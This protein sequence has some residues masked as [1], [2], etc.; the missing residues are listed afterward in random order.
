MNKLFCILAF[1]SLTASAEDRVLGALQDKLLA[2]QANRLTTDD[3]VAFYGTLA[4]A[5]PET[6]QYQVLL[7]GA[8]VQKMRET[9][10]FGYV[11]R[12]EK[13]LRH[14]LE[15]DS[16]NYE[17]LRLETEI[18]L[19]RHN[20]ATVVDLSRRLIGTAPLDAWNWGTLG[21]AYIELG[22]YG[23]AADAYQKMVNLRPDLASY[24]RAAH[25]RYLNNDVKG[26]IASMQ[27]AINAGSNSP[28][29]VAWCWV[30]LGAYYAKTGQNQE[31][32]RAYTSA[33]RTFSNYHPAY[34]AL[35]KLQAAKG[36]SEKAIGNLLRAQSITPLPD[37]A[38]AL[39]DLYLATGK[40][41]EASQ[42]K[43]LIEVID[44]LGRANGEKANRNLAL[45]Y[46]DHDWNLPRSLELAT[47]ELAYRQDVYTYDALAWALYK[48]GRYAEAA[49]A[50]D[51]A[52]KLNT[53]EPGFKRH[54][55]LIHVAIKGE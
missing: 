11:D 2:E 1:A 36:E 51:Q 14:V 43:H 31:A 29:N 22:D 23:Q 49:Q 3:C 15:S 30:E 46:A 8:Y 38:A 47:A 9:T 6:L 25:F 17:A 45:I 44:Q 50:M 40:K 35:G 32:E 28:E 12:A 54:A 27:L 53:P 48:N 10:D 7:A 52:L 24:N 21:D 37:Y 55:E 26:A 18:Q 41:D 20:F 39:Y 42:Q 16:A 19:E 5:R 13:L 34:A 33:I 4:Q